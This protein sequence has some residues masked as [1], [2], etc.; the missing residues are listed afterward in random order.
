MRNHE[1]EE[2]LLK[3]RLEDAMRHYR[4]IEKK[5]ERFPREKRHEAPR[6]TGIWQT[7]VALLELNSD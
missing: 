2:K 4:K 1:Q 6:H 7:D 5:L 3:K